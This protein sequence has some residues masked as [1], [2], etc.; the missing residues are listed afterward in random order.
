MH[1]SKYGKKSIKEIEGS[2]HE[3]LKKI[4][5]GQHRSGHLKTHRLS[6]L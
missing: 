6:E 3:S 5:G 4:E 1:D 2:H